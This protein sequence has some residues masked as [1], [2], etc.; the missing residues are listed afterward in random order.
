MDAAQAAEVMT[1]EW[2]QRHFDHLSPELAADL[3]PTLARMRSGCPVAHS[4][5]YDGFWVVTKYDDVLRVAQDW[6]TF[7][8]AYGLTVPV[9]PIVTRNI[10]VEVDPPIQRVYKRLINTHF[11][12]AVVAQWEDRTRDLVNRLIDDFVEDGECDFMAAFARTYPAMSFFD[13]ALNAPP[14]D[15]E[16]V[17][18]LASKAGLPNDPDA[19]ACW[20]GLSQWIRDFA[21][22]RRREPARGDVVDAVLHADIEGRPITEDEVI[23][24]L[25]L[26]VLG[27]LETTAGALGQMM[28]RFC[29]QPE[30]PALLRDKPEL[31]TDAVEELLRLDG[32]FIAIGRTATRDTEIGGHGIKE[33]E[34]VIIYWAS[35]N[36]D[37]AEF[38][39]PDTFD[40]DRA[41]NRH[42]AFGAGP[43]R[44]AGSNLARMNLRIALEELLPRLDDLALRP[45]AEIEFHSTF[46]RAPRAVPITFTPGP[47]RLPRPGAPR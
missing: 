12:A 13:H 8:S 1:D 5:R 7:S 30:I 42:I 38:V 15:I 41:S 27:G 21:E 19:A 32:P 28:I 37:D 26:L 46:N 25:Q 17:T 2:C 9:A 43:H 16:R 14:D 31:I 20:A 35:A 3:Q 36:R 6:E 18:Y 24:T 40:L 33:G 47:R 11:T 29:R 23:G 44:C 22:Q 10:P 39:D 34:K 45:G 4:D